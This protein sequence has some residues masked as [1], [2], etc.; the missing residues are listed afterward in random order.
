MSMG[1]RAHLCCV[2]AKLAAKRLHVSPFPITAARPCARIHQYDAPAGFAKILKCAA[3]RQRRAVARDGA[4]VFN[5]LIN[6]GGCLCEE[7][8]IFYGLL[9]SMDVDGELRRLLEDRGEAIQDRC[10]CFDRIKIPRKGFEVEH[11]AL[12]QVV[13]LDLHGRGFL[14][15]GSSRLLLLLLYRSSHFLCPLRCGYLLGFLLRCCRFL[16]HLRRCSSISLGF[17][18]SRHLLFLLRLGGCF[19]RLLLRRG[20]LLVLLLGS[21]CFLCLGFG[22]SRLLLLLYRSGRLLGFLLRCCRPSS[23]FVAAAASPLALAAAASSFLFCASAA[24]SSA[25]FAAAAA[26]SVGGAVAASH[27]RLRDVKE[28]RSSSTSR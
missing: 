25:F 12:H 26:S 10:V 17:G 4:H 6:D 16:V 7:C 27:W 21:S 23:I 8:C 9:F 28:R 2:Q 15:F 3:A 18:S 1:A 11:L 13:E 24:A 20:R 5:A 14:G 19:F 22:T